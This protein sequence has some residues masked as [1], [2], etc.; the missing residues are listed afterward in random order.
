MS[1]DV[2]FNEIIIKEG[3]MKIFCIFL[4]IICVI[5]LCA[6][7][8]SK[9]KKYAHIHISLKTPIASTDIDIETE[10]RN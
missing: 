1:Q 3:F 4:L 2:I 10:D 8:L 5:C 7:V 6:F 9:I